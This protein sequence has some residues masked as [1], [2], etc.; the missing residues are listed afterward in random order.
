[1]NFERRTR[2]TVYSPGIELKPLLRRSDAKRTGLIRLFEPSA[3]FKS[4]EEDNSTLLQDQKR[5]YQGGIG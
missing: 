1:L 4:E 3:F 2:K 5:D